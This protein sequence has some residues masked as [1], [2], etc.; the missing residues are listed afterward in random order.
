MTSIVHFDSGTP[1]SNSNASNASLITAAASLR[2]VNGLPPFVDCYTTPWN[3]GSGNI[4]APSGTG[5]ADRYTWSDGV[6]PSQAGADYLGRR[7]AG[8]FAK[9]LGG[10]Y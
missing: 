6:H 3:S 9:I 2:K 4:A 1:S 5:T 8:E 10:G 7:F